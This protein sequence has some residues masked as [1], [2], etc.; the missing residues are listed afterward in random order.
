MSFTDHGHLFSQFVISLCDDLPVYTTSS[1]QGPP[2]SCIENCLTL[3]HKLGRVSYLVKVA[4]NEQHHSQNLKADG[5]EVGR[6]APHTWNYLLLGFCIS[7]T[8][9]LYDLMENFPKL[10]YFATFLPPN[11]PYETHECPF[12]HTSPPTR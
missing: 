2:S 10:I 3:Y 11:V 7:T 5:L 9:R 6:I 8:L 1:H 12:I 4:E